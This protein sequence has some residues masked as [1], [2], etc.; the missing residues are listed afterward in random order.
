MAPALSGPRSRRW[1]CI[2]SPSPSGRWWSSHLTRPENNT[3][4]FVS[5]PKSPKFHLWHCLSR[6]MFQSAVWISRNSKRFWEIRKKHVKWK[7]GGGSSSLALPPTQLR[8]HNN[9]PTAP[10]LV[11]LFVQPNWV[12]EPERSRA[13]EPC[14]LRVLQKRVG[15]RYRCFAPQIDVCSG[16]TLVPQ[17]PQTTAEAALADSSTLRP[18][19]QKELINLEKVDFLYRTRLNRW[20]EDWRLRGISGVLQLLSVSTP[21]LIVH[22]GD[23][24]ITALWKPLHYPH[25]IQPIWSN[26]ETGAATFTHKHR[27]WFFSIRG[28]VVSS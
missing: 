2:C 18:V 8:H 10:R 14:T 15:S 20:E 12:S 21:P 9:I 19:H 5:P 7:S 22:Q 3:R 23:Y 16:A 13:T 28:R 24:L 1:S 26:N 27:P 25:H 11:I 17:P 4:F 6:V